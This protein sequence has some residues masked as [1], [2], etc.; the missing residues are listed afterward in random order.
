M[1]TS[2]PG[3]LTVGTY[4]L[5]LSELACGQLEC[6]GNKWFIVSDLPIEPDRYDEQTLWS[7]HRIGVPILFNFFHGVELILKDF[8]VQNKISTH[9]HKPGRLGWANANPNVSRKQ[10]K[11]R[12]SE[13][14]DR[15]VGVR[16]LTPTYKATACMR[17]IN[18]AVPPSKQVGCNKG[19]KAVW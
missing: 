19:H 8:L 5:Q 15:F 14:A 6:N 9:G 1:E 17:W 11:L 7:D 12:A 10:R 16:K 2:A 4:F 13:S 18:T 3:Y